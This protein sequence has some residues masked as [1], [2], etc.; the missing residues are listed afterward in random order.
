MTKED[1]AFGQALLTE[2][3]RDEDSG[4][5]WNIIDKQLLNKGIDF[6]PPQKMLRLMDDYGLIEYRTTDDGINM[7]L[8]GGMVSIKGPGIEAEGMGLANWFQRRR[9][10]EDAAHRANLATAKGYDLTRW[11]VRFMLAGMAISVVNL[12]IFYRQVFDPPVPSTQVNAAPA[13]V[14]GQAVNPVI[15]DTMRADVRD[16]GR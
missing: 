4:I 6:H 16:T 14:S 9:E 1:I 3:V 15:L 11:G 5:A 2:L 12:F 10:R 8:T 7:L 13:T